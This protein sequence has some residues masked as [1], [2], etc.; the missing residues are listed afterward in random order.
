VMTSHSDNGE[1]EYMRSSELFRDIL[2]IEKVETWQRKC[3]VLWRLQGNR[4]VHNTVSQEV[5]LSKARNARMCCASA[6][7]FILMGRRIFKSIFSKA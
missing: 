7:S 5:V 2:E 6:A 4:G 3:R 1:Y